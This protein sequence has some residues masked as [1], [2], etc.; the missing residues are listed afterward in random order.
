M[1]QNLEEIKSRFLGTNLMIQLGC[2]AS[3]LARIK[4]FSEMPDNKKALEDLIEESK[5]F[6]EWTVP[7]APEEIRA[8]LVRLQV[9]LALWGYPVNKKEIAKVADDWSKRIIDLSGLL[10]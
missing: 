5:F 3:D 10:R 7:R 8:E 6:I 9:Q 1:M 2:I 4:S